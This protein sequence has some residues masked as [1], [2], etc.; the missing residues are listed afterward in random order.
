MKT[1]VNYCTCQY[2]FV[3]INQMTVVVFSKRVKKLLTGSY[4]SLRQESEAP[5]TQSNA[6]EDSSINFLLFAL[7]WF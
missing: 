5:V 1:V 7:P 4:D 6:T 3:K 2:R